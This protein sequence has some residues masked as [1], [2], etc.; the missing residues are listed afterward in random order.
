MLLAGVMHKTE[1]AIIKWK[2]ILYFRHLQC[3][4]HTQMRHIL[5]RQ[6]SFNFKFS[7]SKCS[8]VRGE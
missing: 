7:L 5:F 1:P 8:I 6:D 4:T 2:D 3:T